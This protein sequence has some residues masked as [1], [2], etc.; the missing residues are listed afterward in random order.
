MLVRRAAAGH[1]LAQPP[2]HMARELEGN[3]GCDEPVRL[4]EAEEVVAEEY[5]QAAVL[6]GARLGRARLVLEQGDV[7]E[8]AA[9]AD[10]G[11][12]ARLRLALAAYQHGPV[13]HDVDRL[14]VLA[15][16][17]DDLVLEEFAFVQ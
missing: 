11:E 6:G 14:P 13:D 17:E 4:H 15:L 10:R 9:G 7:A 12:K 3:L 1:R 2:A 5:G 8:E 16:V